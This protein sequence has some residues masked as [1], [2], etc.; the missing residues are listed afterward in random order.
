MIGISQSGETRDTIEAMKLAR[1]MG[2]HTVALTNMMGSQI[3]REVDSVLYTR[4]GLEVSVAAS[5]T[6]TAQLSL[7]FLVALKLAQ[8]RK[9]LPPEELEFIV[10]AVYKLPEQI[11]QFL[12]AAIRSRDRPPSL[13]QAVL[14]LPGPQH[15][16]AGRARGRAEA[17]GA[18]VHPDRGLLGR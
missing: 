4:A 3:T 15:R 17:E 13:R 18:L 10:N 12:G 8:V 2:A 5:K 7:L 16:P 6:F 9:T 14:P 11:E 1:A